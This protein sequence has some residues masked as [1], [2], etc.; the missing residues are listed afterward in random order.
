MRRCEGR[1]EDRAFEECFVQRKSTFN[2]LQG[3]ELGM[4]RDLKEASLAAVQGG[5]GGCS[6]K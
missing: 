1:E 5:G 6:W 2:T 4:F 3:I